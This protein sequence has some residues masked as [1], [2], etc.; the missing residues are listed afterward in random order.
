MPKESARSRHARED[1]KRLAAQINATNGHLK[2]DAEGRPTTDESV[3]V[4]A[5]R[6]ANAGTWLTQEAHCLL[7][8][9]SRRVRQEDTDRR[10][11]ALAAATL[12]C[13]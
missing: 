12:A 8:E 5:L 3:T 9:E 10:D 13:P 1:I 2:A 6:L 4:L 7:D 11:A